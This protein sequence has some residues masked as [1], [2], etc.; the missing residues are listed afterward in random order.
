MPLHP[1]VRK[2]PLSEADFEPLKWSE[3]VTPHL[4][5]VILIPK[6][7]KVVTEQHARM[8]VMEALMRYGITPRTEE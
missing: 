3:V 6:G 7:E 5:P 2:P 8:M 4:Q 1:K